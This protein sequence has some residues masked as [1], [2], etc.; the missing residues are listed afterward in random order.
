MA[1][2]WLIH[3]ALARRTAA[4][5]LVD[6]REWALRQ[7]GDEHIATI[8]R[9][10]EHAALAGHVSHVLRDYIERVRR[11]LG[12]DLTTTELLAALTLNSPSPSGHATSRAEPAEAVSALTGMLRLADRVKFAGYHPSAEETASLL[13]LAREWI[14]RWP[15]PVESSPPARRAA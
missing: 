7:L 5:P 1:I 9:P 2:A 3:R 12:R 8:L 14:G 13:G 4:V 6:A 10:D 11:K 15:E